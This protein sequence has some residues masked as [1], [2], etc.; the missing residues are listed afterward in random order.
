MLLVKLGGS[1]LTVK[2]EGHYR[3][4]R[5]EAIHRLA[6]EMAPH[7]EGLAVI[8]GAGSY[9]HTLAKEHGLRE[10]QVRPEQIPAATQVHRDV[11]ILNGLVVEALLE[12]HIPAVAV[13]TS[14]VVRFE[15]GRVVWFDKRP[16]RDHLRLGHV[17]VTF[18]DVVRDT[19]RSF[20][21]CSGDDLLVQLAQEF[22]P[23]LAV[24]VTAVDGVYDR[25]GGRLLE[26]VDR[27]VL[28]R[29]DFASFGEGDATGTMREK[30][31]KMLEVARH[32]KRTLI[33]GGA[34]GRLADALAGK[35]VPGTRVLG[36]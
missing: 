36:G 4:P 11:R 24:A 5:P 3:E 14:E 8:H 21:I 32:A 2:G 34:P 30:L 33:I 25:E 17:P 18:G 20:T 29:I 28:P 7:A 23:D 27:A 1:V 15:D 16:F 26:T 22:R 19:K 35:D 6:A 31:E 12:V 9:G 10:G 13:S